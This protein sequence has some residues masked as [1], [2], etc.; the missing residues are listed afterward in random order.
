MYSGVTGLVIGLT[1]YNYFSG[2]D[3]LYFLIGV[4]GLAGL[5][6]TTLLDFAVQV[7]AKGGLNITVNPGGTEKQE[8]KKDDSA[9]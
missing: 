5:G 2:R 7:V 8:E 3:N 1:W 9:S 6:G 4:S